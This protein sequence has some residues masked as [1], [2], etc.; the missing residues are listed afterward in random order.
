MKELGIDTLSQKR[1]LLELMSDGEWHGSMDLV[2]AVGISWNQRKN[3][4]RREEGIVVDKRSKGNAFEYRLLTLI[5]KIDLQKCELKEPLDRTAQM[6]FKIGSKV[7]GDD[8]DYK[9]EAKG[10]NGIIYVKGPRG[11][12]AM[13]EKTLRKIGITAI[14]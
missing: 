6:S 12:V 4:L 14:E 5:E 3:E 10:L 8:G 13:S 9:I 11:L 2:Q 1:H 7:K